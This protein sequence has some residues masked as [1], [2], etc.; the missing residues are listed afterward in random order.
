MAKPDED[1]PVMVAIRKAL[2]ASG[3][4][5]QELGDKMG[6]PSE[7]ARKSVSQL[8]RGHDPR[9]GTVRRFA[10]AIGIPLAKLVK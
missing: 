9:V 7:S 4:T 1:D 8:L 3:M 2:A 5:Q 6:Y 10:K